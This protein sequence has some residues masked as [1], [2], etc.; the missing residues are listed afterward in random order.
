MIQE[1]R[2]KMKKETTL[3]DCS[4]CVESFNFL[5]MLL[6]SLRLQD[7]SLLDDLYVPPASSIVEM[8]ECDWF[9]EK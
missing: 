5:G 4:K 8:M 6:C 2:I 9:K 7:K 3:N 1:K